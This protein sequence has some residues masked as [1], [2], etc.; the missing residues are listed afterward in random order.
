MKRA[1]SLLAASLCLATTVSCASGSAVE[2]A[3]A[4]PAVAPPPARAA[5]THSEED[6]KERALQGRLASALDYVS[7]IRSLPATSEVKGR[8]IGR[9]EI[10]TFIQGELDSDAPPDVLEA[11]TAILYGFG[12]VDASFDYRATIVKLM[13]SQLLGFYDPKRKTFFVGGDLSGDEADVTLWHELVHALQDQHYDLSHLTEY[14]VDGGDR[15]SAVHALAEGDATSAMLDAM[16]SP[17]GSTALDVP[18]SLFQ[19]QSVLGAAA[20]TEAPP[21]LVRS[22]LAPYIDGLSFTNAL[23]RQGGFAAVDAAWRTPPAS[24]EQLLHPAKFLSREAPLIVPL[25][26][27]PSFAPELT[28]RFHDVMGEQ[29]VRLLLEEWLPARTAAA[30]ASDWG[31]DRLSAFAD[32]AR[33]RWAVGWHLRYDNVAAAERAFDA[34]ARAAPSM[35]RGS[36]ATVAAPTAAK[37]PRAPAKLCLQ[38]HGQGALAL[39]RRQADLAVAVG[40]F[41]RGGAAVPGDPGC[42]LVQA[43]AETIASQ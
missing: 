11:T 8:L 20:V 30:A 32:D 15:Q 33:Q 22:L 27:A 31:G 38:R 24:T 26:S 3:P 1:R 34:F 25:P 42:A 28:E 5:S 6:P 7:R 16:L 29:M 2:V 19:A 40:P 12:T 18:E 10:E 21:V 37:G 36:K 14:A 4:P 17:R 41:S 35:E 13:T 9:A 39:V 43:W 23:R